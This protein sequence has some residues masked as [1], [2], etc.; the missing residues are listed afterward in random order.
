[1]FLFYNI[2]GMIAYLQHNSQLIH[3]LRFLLELVALKNY[4]L[5][6]IVLRSHWSWLANILQRRLA[7][8]SSVE[9]KGA[10]FSLHLGSIQSERFGIR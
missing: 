5:E 3:L 7:F 9:Y 4:L 2:G 10:M 8:V 1:M 6:R